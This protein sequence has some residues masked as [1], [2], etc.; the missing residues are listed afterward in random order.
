MNGFSAQLWMSENP[1]ECFTANVPFAY[2]GVAVDPRAQRHFRIV[3]VNQAN[4]FQ[5]EV[6][7][8]LRS[9]ARNPLVDT[10]SKPAAS[11]WQVS[12]QKPIGKLV[13][14][15]IRSSKDCSSSKRLPSAD[16]EPAV[17]SNSTIGVALNPA[18]A[19]HSPAATAANAFFNGLSAKTAG[20]YH[21]ILG[22]DGGR[23]LQ[24]ATKGGDRPGAN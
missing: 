1:A 7:S 19:S 20:M 12:R 2:M 6:S 13:R 11:K 15:R 23:A 4:V 9:V 24:F 5:P 17:F 14:G 21:Q 16:P 8:A 10:I 22:A 3:G 18:A